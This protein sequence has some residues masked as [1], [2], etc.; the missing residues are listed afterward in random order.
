MRVNSVNN[1]Y[2]DQKQQ[3][4]GATVG[5]N[6]EKGLV[7]FLEN[8]RPEVQRKSLDLL[9]SPQAVQDFVTAVKDLKLQWGIPQKT[10][11]PI[12]NIDI[13][14][15]PG[16]M[17]K[18]NYHAIRAS[19][20]GGNLGNIHMVA[21][22]STNI[23]SMIFKRAKRIA[24]WYGDVRTEYKFNSSSMQK[25]P[26]TTIRESVAKLME[27]LRKANAVETA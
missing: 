17:K 7:S 22:P 10:L 14:T 26:E 21:Q 15:T 3:N 25:A 20:P 5:T 4:F 18:Y 13:H 12:L 27:A 1:N 8:A 23:F 6:F 11:A 24:S 2:N 16:P 9:N 19:Y